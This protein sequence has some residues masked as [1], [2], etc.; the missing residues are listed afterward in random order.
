MTRPHEIEA[1]TMALQQAWD[2]VDVAAA[3]LRAMGSPATCDSCI[4]APGTRSALLC[5]AH[6]RGLRAFR[7]AERR[8]DA[9]RMA[10]ILARA[11]QRRERQVA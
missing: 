11:R 10:L 7:E 9:L 6:T 8:R 1:A 3:Q 5:V 2:A 4:A